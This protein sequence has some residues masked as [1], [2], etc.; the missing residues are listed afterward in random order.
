MVQSRLEYI[1]E[2]EKLEK[3]Y[4]ELCDVA[5]DK[6]QNYQTNLVVLSSYG[7]NLQKSTLFWQRRDIEY[8]NIKKRIRGIKI[9]RAKL[10]EEYEVK[11]ALKTKYIDVVIGQLSSINCS[12]DVFV[13]FCIANK[14][15]SL[16]D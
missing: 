15:G 5:R 16:H 9:L 11:Q 4:Q 13:D 14:K 8:F 10:L 2:K 3:D 12:S 7:I 6:K 1:L